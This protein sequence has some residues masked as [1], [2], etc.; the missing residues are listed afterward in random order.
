M[1]T[2]IHRQLTLQ[3]QTSNHLHGHHNKQ[4]TT[5]PQTPHIISHEI[6]ITSSSFPNPKTKREKPTEVDVAGCEKQPLD[7]KLLKN[8]AA[9]AMTA[10]L[11]PPSAI[12]QP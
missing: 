4:H 8:G 2:N 12:Q 3:T 7:G 10:R 11:L 6:T 9:P 5:S 1:L